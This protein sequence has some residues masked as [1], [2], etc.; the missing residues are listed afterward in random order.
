M[1][2][3][4][5]QQSQ[6]LPF[7]PQAQS[8]VYRLP[9]PPPGIGLGQQVDPAAF[10][11]TPSFQPLGQALQGYADQLQTQIQQPQAQPQQGY[12]M[13]PNFLQTPEAQA[14][15]QQVWDQN[16]RRSIQ[17]GRGNAGRGAQIFSGLIAPALAIFGGNG[18]A[19]ASARIVEQGQ[20]MGQ[21]AKKNQDQE[22]M[23]AGSALRN[24]ANIVNQ[25]SI[26]PVQE[27]AKTAAQIEK[28][29]MRQQGRQDLA[30]IQGGYKIL[31]TQ[32]TEEGKNNR[33]DTQEQGRNQRLDKQEEGRT[34]RNMLTN[35]VRQTLGEMRSTDYNRALDLRESAQSSIEQYRN[36][37]LQL[38]SGRD[39][40]NAATK[41]EELRL[42][43]LNQMS[44]HQLEVNKFNYGAAKDAMQQMAGGGFKYADKD[45]NAL[46]PTKFMSELEN[47]TS[48]EVDPTLMQL[49][50]TPIQVPQVQ[51]QPQQQQ[52]Q[53]AAPKQ[54]PGK[55]A[56]SPTG[57]V[58]PP[59]P[60]AALQSSGG[61]AAHVQSYGGNAAQ[62]KQAFM[63][64]LIRRGLPYQQAAMAADQQ[65]GQ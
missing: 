60:M 35:Y 63:Q 30:H 14:Q 32:M 34:K 17:A 43:A 42:K 56:K 37:L 64:A 15:L 44:K 54:A 51:T 21:Q 25:T 10:A 48:L 23:A 28:E 24:I 57:L 27:T 22:E 36:A 13:A 46:D 5:Y 53:Q 16:I 59:P 11:T 33:L 47:T 41:A 31:N 7:Q 61:V 6:Y 19:I 40:R 62:A 52:A 50:Q 45:G 38:Q 2:E 18:G 39:N 1:D 55:R 49:L 20:Q 9:P 58:P 26:R 4:I 8:L 65:Y 3:Q 29:R 12:Q